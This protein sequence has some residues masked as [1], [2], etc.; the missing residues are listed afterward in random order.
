MSKDFYADPRMILNEDWRITKR[1]LQ[2]DT[3]MEG[4]TN[5]VSFRLEYIAQLKSK[6]GWIDQ[7]FCTMNGQRFP[8]IFQWELDEQAER[9]QL[10]Y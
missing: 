3:K 9:K 4:T 2:C 1:I 8:E 7:Y 6:E 5:K 10:S